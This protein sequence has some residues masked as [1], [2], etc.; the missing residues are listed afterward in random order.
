VDELRKRKESAIKTAEAG[1]AKGN[2]AA[3]P[4]QDEEDEDNL[5]DTSLLDWRAKRV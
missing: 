2:H 5:D 1:T 4:A 3:K